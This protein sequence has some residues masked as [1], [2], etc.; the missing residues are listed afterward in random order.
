MTR[1]GEV[2]LLVWTGRSSKCNSCLP[3]SP[4][5]YIQR[6]FVPP[7]LSQAKLENSTDGLRAA[8]PRS[9]AV[10]IYERLTRLQ[11]VRFSHCC[12]HL[13]CIV[14]CRTH[15]RKVEVNVYLTETTG[16]GDVEFTTA[17]ALPIGERRRLVFVDTRIHGFHMSDSMT[18][19]EG[20]SEADSNPDPGNSNADMDAG[21][22]RVP[23]IEEVPLERVRLEV[24]RRDALCSVQGSGSGCG[25]RYGTRLPLVGLQPLRQDPCHRQG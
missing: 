16:L 25:L 10:V 6:P 1:S 13:P 12:L 3:S 4:A 8:S 21:L 24:T 22:V 15:L 11:P 20:R 5:A 19:W 17:D 18:R 7:G 14:F 2:T 23:I 9:D